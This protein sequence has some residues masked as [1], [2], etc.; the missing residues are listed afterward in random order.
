MVNQALARLYWPHQNAVGKHIVV[1]LGTRPS[2]IVGVLSDVHNFALASDV[3]PEI[4]FPF[5][6]LPGYS[7]N[8]I[9]RTERD[10]RSMVKP[11]EQSVLA[12]D[13]EQPVTA[14][15]TM[16]DVLET[17]AAQPRFTTSLLAALALAALILAVVGIYGAI[18]Y[19]VSERTQEMAIRLALGA[20]PQH[21]LRLVLGQGMWLAGAGIALGIAASLGLTRLLESLLYH[22]SPS[23]PLTF[24]AGAL[25]FVCVALAASYVPARRAMRVDPAVTLH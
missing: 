2:E 16:D 22:V 8:L 20:A 1:G 7:L 15:Q 18:G 4:Y 12:L 11:I 19:S 6:Q 10:P 23:D 13:P 25:L 17:G 9:V 3:K 21:I 24:G 14:V 5:A